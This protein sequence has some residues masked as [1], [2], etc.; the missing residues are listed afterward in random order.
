MT[1]TEEILDSLQEDYQY[2]KNILVMLTDNERIVLNANHSYSMFAEQFD[3]LNKTMIDIEQAVEPAYSI[4]QVFHSTE[5][6]NNPFVHILDWIRA[7]QLD[8]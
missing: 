4:K 2:F 3:R 1:I 6:T 7:E 5:S 8:I